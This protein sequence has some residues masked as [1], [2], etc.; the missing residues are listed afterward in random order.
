MRRATTALLTLVFALSTSAVALADPGVAPTTVD[1][2]ADPGQVIDVVKT[3]T[4]PEIPPD[5][6]IVFLVDTTTSMGPAI[7]N[8]QANLGTILATVLGTQPTAQFGVA[9]YKDTA[10]AEPE[11]AVLQD[12][13]GDTVAVTNGIMNLTPLSGGGFDAPEDGIN[14]LYQL[15]NG[16]VTWRADGTPVIVWIGDA[17][18]HDPS[19]GHTLTDAI[20]ALVGA[21]IIVIAVDVGPTPGQISDGLDNTGQATAVVNATGGSL[22][23]VDPTGLSAAILANLQNLPVDVTHSASCDP[24]LTTT[25]SPASLVVP[26]GSDAVFA[27]QITVDP[28]APQG[29]TLGC[30]VT[31]LL[32][33]EA[34]GP[35]FVQTIT[36]HVNDVEPPVVTV[37]DKTVEATGPDGAIIDY[38]ATAV[39]NVDGPL[40]PTCV[41]PS[42]SLFPIGATLVT[43]EATDSSGLTGS[44][45]AT[46]TVV[47]TTPPE[48]AC[49]ETTNPSGKNTPKAKEQNRDGF[50]ALHAEDL[51][52]GAPELYVTDDADPSVVFGPFDSDTSIKLIQAPGAD[53][54]MK[55]GPKAIDYQIRLKGDAILTAVDDFGNESHPVSCRVPPKPA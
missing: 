23:T 52:D 25:L 19:N 7:A 43:C 9:E 47:D 42:G 29:A 21:G 14:G 20:N 12:L 15:A 4:T 40:V 33:G 49:V 28:A 8:V 39:D 45:T 37:D 5:P 22:A 44:D 1:H 24:G 13:T 10:D 31:F 55:P 6:D 18:S 48:A 17:S 26:S 16:A 34:G 41:P 53:Q 50:Y 35:E 30:T 38:E 54:S 36:I 3:V 51:V 11:F 32:N 46:M 27:E 2:N